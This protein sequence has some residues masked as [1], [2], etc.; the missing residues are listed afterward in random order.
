MSEST[1][2]E[3]A[4]SLRSFGKTYAGHRALRGVDLDIRGGEVHALVGENGCGK[5]TLIKCL[6]GYQDPDGGSRLVVAGEQVDLPL[7]ESGASERGLLFVHQDFGIIGSL[8]VMENIAMGAGFT[9]RSGRIRWA[10]QA[11]DTRRA[12]AVLGRDDIDPR[13]Q[14]STLSVAE[15]AIVAIAR[16]LARAGTSTRLLVLDEPT[17]AL[18]HSEVE[19]VF[20]AV[21]RLAASG[22]SVL[23]VSHRLQE[24]FEL[25]D[26]ITVLRDGE[27][28]RT[29]AA[30]EI[31]ERELVRLMVG[32]PVETMYPEVPEGQ[33][34]REVLLRVSG[35]SGTRATDV[36]FGVRRGEIVGLAG[37]QGSGRS[38]IIRMIAGVQR[39]RAG[40]I[41]VGGLSHRFACPADAIAVGVA[42]VP[43]DRLRQGAIGSLSVGD[44][45]SLLTLERFFRRGRLRRRVEHARSTELV[46][47]FNVRP[48]NVS[49]PMKR[50][51]GGNQQK[52]ILAK[53]IEIGPRVL[54]LD[55]PSQGI[56]IAAKSDIYHQIERWVKQTS[57]AVLVVSSDLDDL[58]A[59]CHR[60]LVLR[61]GQVVAEL[62]GAEKSVH[63]MAE[64]SQWEDIA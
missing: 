32:R 26:R 1:R 35:L 2:T 12:L 64:L 7:G 33:R 27:V 14:A 37:I 3:P 25:A 47:E 16:S 20:R 40:T 52:A 45:I 5:S 46:G 38:E 34:E 42:H 9:T 17:A 21:R 62:E 44:N 28:V 10:E 39:P 30:A 61:D 43:E 55:E 57:S 54:L 18:P 58:R 13:A 31:D 29:V 15:Q 48:G 41:E 24:V 63:R 19:H 8:S 59:L 4:V 23:F 56:D 50:L 49:A 11:E 6:S 22:V 36:S 60:V 53:W 51:S